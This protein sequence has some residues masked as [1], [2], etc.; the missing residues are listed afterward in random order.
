[1]MNVRKF[2]IAFAA[3]YLGKGV[4]IATRYSYLRTQFLDS[5][6]VER[7]V[8]DYQTQQLK[9]FDLL[10]KTYVMY[11]SFRMIEEKINQMN[12][13]IEQGDFRSLQEIHI[14]LS[15]SKAFFTWWC[16]NGLITCISACGGH[17]YQLYSGIPTL[18]Y[19]FSPNVILEGENTVLVQQVGRYL[20]K[21]Y[22]NVAQNKLDKVVG[23]CS[24]FK[25]PTFH[26]YKSGWDVKDV[27]N[28]QNLVS[29]LKSCAYQTT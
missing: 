8:I 4:A 12:K 11:G 5:Q 9:L 27:Q 24:Y 14:I 10:A 23:H 28:Y 3:T 1:M 18:I 7:P 17:G 26:N 20:L 22:S 15:G 21:C 16:F 25:D 6:K 2:L 13:E 29:L 19:S